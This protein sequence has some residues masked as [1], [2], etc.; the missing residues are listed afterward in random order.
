[1]VA[2]CE[3]ELRFTDPVWLLLLIPAFGGLYWSFKRVHGMARN[4]KRL[5]FAIRFLLVGALIFALSG[6]EARRANHGVATIFL[7]DKSDS[8]NGEE[9][10][11]AQDFVSEA[12]QKLG[13]EDAAGL[14]VFGRDALIDTAPGGRRTLG[15][16]LSKVD[17]SSSDLAG[18]IRL[19]SATFPDGKARRIVVL[20]DGN[21]TAG[22]AEQAALV[23][24][25]DNIDIDY[26]PLGIEDKQ[27][28]ASVVDLLTPDEIRVDQPF[29]LKAIIDSTSAGRALLEIDRDGKLVKSV[30][31]TLNAG[32]NSIVVSDKLND[33]GFSRYRATLKFEGDR[34]SRNNVGMGF[35]VVKGKPRVL[36]MQE[37]PKKKELADAL[38]KAGIDIDLGGPGGLPTRPEQV[39]RYD[40][41]IFNDI[42][43]ASITE[44]QMKL[45]QSA[46]RDSGV[47]FA[48]V[49]G[50]NSFLPGGY[51]GTPIAEVL[52]VD[53]NI[54][55][56]K[57]FPSTSVLI[58]VDCSGSMSMIEDGVQKLRMAAKAAEETVKLMAPTDRVGVAGSSDGIE[59]VAPMQ[60]LTD[61]MSVISQI[62]KL[63]VTGGGIYIGPSIEAADPT[64]RKEPSKVRH[65]ILLADGNDSTDWRDAIQRAMAMRADKIT[66]TVIAI[67]EGKDVP[68]LQQLA[69]AGGGRFYLATKARQLPAIFTQDA[70]IMSRSAIEEG[71]FFPK[72]V[73]GE[74]IMRGIDSLPGLLAY[75]LTDSRPLSKVGM[76]THKDDPLLATWQYGLGTSLAFTSDAQSRWAKEWVGWEGF[77]AF[78]SQAIRSISRR[79][80]ENNYQV[81]VHQEGG[82]GVIEMKGFDRLGNALNQ[83][84][85]TVRIAAPNGQSKETTLTQQAPGFFTGDFDASELGSYIVTVAE[86]DKSGGSRVSSSGFSVAYPPE[87]RSFRP[88]RPLLA[89]VSKA[90]HGQELKSPEQALRAAND[91]GA[92]ITELWPL[93]VLIATLLLP[94]DIA[95]R[96]LA[97]PLSEILAKALARFQPKRQTVG[98]QVEVVGRLQQAKLRAKSSSGEEESGAPAVP[99]RTSISQEARPVAPAKP[100][101]KGA[102]ASSSLLEAK[103]KRSEEN[104]KT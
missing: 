48:M 97:L 65:F 78:W 69:S 54:R 17:G 27:K 60:P 51:Y 103:R 95:V 89:R 81:A 90:T 41:V 76:K 52:P 12:M 3:E 74:E 2:V 71:R 102:T 24:Q 6:P 57:S 49:G 56:R 62:R 28:E 7:L 36:V 44:P 68:M 75:C 45:L 101:K 25:T 26:V 92:S 63:D 39:Q 91:P 47:G 55:Q 29:D 42:N 53:L 22:D 50:E 19:A 104:K 32:R 37:D 67:G 38:Q 21:E 33:A 100:L 1:M 40:A 99:I 93:L 79:A 58:I 30:P 35:V 13:S 61:K 43:A 31:V 10:R 34:D 73:G 15:Q 66:T 18:A 80:T 96:R 72:V 14:I 94:I 4:R 46:V 8:I 59:F 16:V 77:G 83:E 20:S 87:Y 82:K 9:S 85:V 70:A 86:K 23:A 64:L 11:R 98:A 88:N 5:A 84:N